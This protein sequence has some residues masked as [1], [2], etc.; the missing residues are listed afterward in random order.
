MKALPIA[1]GFVVGSTCYASQAFADYSVFHGPG[2]GGTCTVRISTASA[3]QYPDV[4]VTKPTMEEACKAAKALKTED[5]SENKKCYTYDTDTI[6]IC[7]GKGVV[8]KD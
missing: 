7:K 8:L 6:K 4:F 1:I 3:P 5:T 2:F